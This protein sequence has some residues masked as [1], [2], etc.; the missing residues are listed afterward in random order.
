[1]IM[2]L[3]V[4]LSSELKSTLFCGIEKSIYHKVITL[5]SIYPRLQQFRRRLRVKVI[6]LLLIQA[7]FKKKSTD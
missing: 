1:M 5:H 4:L 7:A 6:V 2:S 3:H